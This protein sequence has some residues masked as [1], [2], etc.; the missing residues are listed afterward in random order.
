MKSI[1]TW[2]AWFIWSH[3]A[4]YLL[5]LWHEVIIIDDLSWWFE[6]NIPEWAIF[7]K[8]DITDWQKID[9]IFFVEKPDYVYHAAAFACEGLSHH[10]KNFIYKNI[11]IWGSNIINA[12]VNHNVKRLVHFSSMAV[13]GEWEVPYHECDIK[14]PEDSYGIAKRAME[15]DLECSAKK[16]WL[17]YTIFNPHNLYWQWQNIWD[18]F[19]NVVGIFI[20]QT[21]R[22]EPMTIFGDW[23]QIRAFTYVDDVIPSIANCVGMDNTINQTY[24]IW[25]DE[26]YTINKLAETVIKV[27]WR[28]LIKY[29]E[30]RYEVGVAYCDHG[31]L[32]K[33][34][35]AY[36]RTTTSLEDWIREM[37]EWA[38]ELWPQELSHYNGIEITKTL[39]SKR[40]PYVK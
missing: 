7:Y 27:A 19:R 24:N 2:W 37:W 13:Y 23:E 20:N 4:K 12:C 36:K 18:T 35:P 40:I 17:E 8:Q 3:L 29:L 1:V 9:E 30:P 33:D 11:C 26:P 10:I 28:G 5:T 15:L 31:K 16:F 39:H 21:L 14:N 22:N 34:F 32:R 38:K 6:R 25:W